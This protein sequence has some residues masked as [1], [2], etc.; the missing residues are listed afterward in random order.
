MQN[1]PNAIAAFQPR[2]DWSD[3]DFEDC[4]L[5]TC[6]KT[7]GLVVQESTYVFVYGAGLYSFF[8]NYDS[9]CIT[10][11][12]CQQYMVSIQSSEA[13]YLFGLNT[14]AVQTLVEVDGV[15]LVP[16]GANVNTFCN[17]LALF[18]YP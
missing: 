17:T 8:N 3:P 16:A 15:S 4:F 6:A 11:T 7:Y 12:N 2:E 9:G 14:V 10:T 13:V 1:N 5:P 18:E